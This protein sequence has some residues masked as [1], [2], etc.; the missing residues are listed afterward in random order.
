MT[1]DLVVLTSRAPDVRAIVDSMVH[2]GETLRVR[3]AGG[4]A[5]IQLCDDDGRPLVNIEAAQRVDVEG[6]VERLLGAEVTAG[7]T[8]PYW[9]VE[10]RA[11]GGRGD[12][13]ALAHRFADAMVERLGGAV[14]PPVAP[15][16]DEEGGN[17]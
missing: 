5:L 13:P 8:V 15:G 16:G 4:G 17:G 14:W 3:G 9:W 11:S 7:L 1:Y 6:E 2:A 10:V 12:A